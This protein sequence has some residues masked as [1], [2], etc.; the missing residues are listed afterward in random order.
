MKRIMDKLIFLILLTTAQ[1][2]YSQRKG[3]ETPCK[4]EYFSDSDQFVDSIEFRIK[5]WSKIDFEMEMCSWSIAEDYYNTT[6]MRDSRI[7]CVIYIEGKNQLND[8]EFI[9]LFDDSQLRTELIDKIQ[10]IYIYDT[11]I[12]F[13]RAYRNK[14]ELLSLFEQKIRQGLPN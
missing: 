8:F 2:A 9:Y 7:V 14:E 10:L 11:Q 5:Y 3:E 4:A 12:G 6:P 13:H 1:M